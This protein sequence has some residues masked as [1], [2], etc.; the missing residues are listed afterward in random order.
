MTISVILLAGGHGSRMKCNLP[1]QYLELHGKPIA[2]YS[3]EMFLSMSDVQEVIVVCDP[4]YC[5]YFSSYGV[6]FALPGERRQDS[7]YNGLKAASCEWICVHDSVR[8]FITVEMTQRLFADGKK[9]G[10]ATVGMP[11]KWTVKLC[12]E[13]NLVQNTLDRNLVWEG[14]TPQFLSKTVLLSGFSHAIEHDLTVTDDVSLA[15]II[16]HP[17]KLVEGAYNNIKI[18]TP[19][20][21]IIAQELHRNFV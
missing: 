11:M 21:M 17:V 20:D 13:N 19:E 5:H 8:P 16:G 6:K 4:A 1:K 7:L 15:E 9:M 12:K 14:Q 18:T 3:L 10:A 2:H